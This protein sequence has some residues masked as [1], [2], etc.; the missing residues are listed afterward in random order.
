MILCPQEFGAAGDGITP[1]TGAIQKALDACADAGGGTL[2]FKQGRYLTGTLK[3]GSNTTLEF[4]AGAEL[5]GSLDLSDYSTDIIGCIECPPFDKCLIY[6]HNRKSLRICGEGTINGQGTA[7]NFPHRKSDGTLGERPMLI[8][9]IDCEDIE[10]SGIRLQNSGSWC[11]NL[12][13]CT[14]I[15]MRNVSI[16][17]LGNLNNDG[18]DFDSCRDVTVD[19]C[20][21]TTEDDSICL[22]SSRTEP[23]SDFKISNCTV[24]SNTAAFKLGTASRSGFRRI[25]LSNCR[26]RNCRYGAVK[27]ICVD[28]GTLEDVEICDVDMNNVEGPLFIRLGSRNMDLS[29]QNMMVYDTVPGQDSGLDFVRSKI[30]NISIKNVT[31]DCSGAELDRCGIMITGVPGGMVENVSLENIGIR[32]PGGGT[33]ENAK[34][35]IAE[36]PARYPEQV[37]FGVLPAY[38][39]Y[40]RHVS[41]L[42]IKNLDFELISPD[43]RPERCYI[44][45]V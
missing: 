1:D 4:A 34:R 10:F 12:V 2:Y 20:E 31:A 26:F 17:N 18:F 25:K 35:E 11:C 8:R 29:R 40:A 16:Y 5:I 24:S 19:N 42:N 27:L 33:A 21:L 43:K 28:G 38:G 36:D 23:C 32:L 6:A 7:E 13:N 44:D 22:K 45:V 3:M 15:V 37:L 30:R 14:G 9:M 39:I 41:G